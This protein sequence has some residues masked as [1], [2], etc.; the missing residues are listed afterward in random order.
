MG[1]TEE[2]EESTTSDWEACY[3]VSGEFSLELVYFS[4]QSYVDEAPDPSMSTLPPAIS[5]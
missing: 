5:A 3:G 2:I 1:R 4:L